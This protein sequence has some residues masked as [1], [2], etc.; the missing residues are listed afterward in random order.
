M[1]SP[2]LLAGL[3]LVAWR[4]GLSTRAPSPE[5]LRAFKQAEYATNAG[6]VQ[7][8]SGIHYYEEAIRLDPAFAE[9]WSGLA[10]AHLAQTWF[11][12]LPAKDTM[13]QAKREAQ[14]A[15]RLDPSLSGPWRVLAAISHYYDWD[16][17]TAEQQ[18]RRA[19][20]L[21]PASSVAL[22]WF[23]EFLIDLGRFDEA[24]AHMRRARRRR[25]GGSNR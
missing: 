1:S 22:S 11:A 20:E 3:L 5:A 17:L 23:A 9:A 14:R 15:L 16:H 4:P 6:R 12:D 18:F 2:V 25:P 24:A 19:I 8:Q 21:D 7:I 13:A 10:S